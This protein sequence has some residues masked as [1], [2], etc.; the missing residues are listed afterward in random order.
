MLGIPVRYLLKH[1]AAAAELLRDPYD[2][3]TRL[4]ESYL[5][6]RERRM[7]PCRYEADH[8]WEP[9]LHEAIGAAWPCPL[10][11]EFGELWT[12]VMRELEAMGIQPGPESFRDW[13]DGDAGFVRAIWCLI[14]HLNL[15]TI[16]ETGVAHG[17]TSR[18]IL[19]ALE[20]NGDGQLSSID[21]PPLER[22][23]KWQVGIAVPAHLTGRWS[24]IAGASRRRLPALLSTLGQIDLFVHDSLHT[25]R[26]VTFELERAWPAL[27]PGSAVVV[28]DI[29]ANWGFHLFT[30][31]GYASQHLV[32]EA[33]PIRPDYRRFNDKG[34]FGIALKPPFTTGHPTAR[35]PFAAVL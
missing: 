21:V 32:C 34:L 18:F 8:D 1:P 20:A 22:D 4:R 15:R 33:E 6:E 7:A 14:R 27:Q 2:T 28:D 24:Y 23:W 29:D 13:N 5:G 26:N 16:V 12:R 35:P 31:R 19:E 25:A 11:A 9:R 30:Q 10:R 3:W 17:V